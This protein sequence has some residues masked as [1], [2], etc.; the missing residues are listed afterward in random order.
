MNS[1]EFDPKSRTL[2]GED[3]ILKQL[4]NLESSEKAALEEQDNFAFE[5]VEKHHMELNSTALPTL[6]EKIHT[7][8]KSKKE[9]LVSGRIG[10]IM[11]RYNI[12]RQDSIPEVEE[13]EQEAIA[14]YLKG[15][16]IV[17]SRYEED[18]FV[19]D[20]LA[21]WGSWYNKYLGWGDG[22]CHNNEKY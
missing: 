20:H 4:T 17:R 16:K 18:V 15:S 8:I 1:A 22:C 11:K 12:N 3:A 6:T 9:G 14:A 19:N 7:S 10:E 5:Q 13:D 21:V 2:A